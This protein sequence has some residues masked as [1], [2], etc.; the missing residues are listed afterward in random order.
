VLN[1]AEEGKK[2]QNGAFVHTPEKTTFIR[3]RA[4]LSEFLVIKA[5]QCYSE[6]T[7]FGGNP[8]SDCLYIQ[9]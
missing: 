1:I 2:K 9:T 7:L 5:C 6:I 3:G 8:N 4:T